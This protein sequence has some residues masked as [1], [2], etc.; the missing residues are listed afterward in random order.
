MADATF[1][2]ELRK[3]F[4]TEPEALPDGAF[5]IEHL[6]PRTPGSIKMTAVRTRLAKAVEDGRVVRIREAR[7]HV[8]AVYVLKQG[9][10]PAMVGELFRPE[11][12]KKAKAR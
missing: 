6:K 11:T 7:G 10:T 12:A 5:T 3:A 2:A 1:W 4:G 9:V 8:P